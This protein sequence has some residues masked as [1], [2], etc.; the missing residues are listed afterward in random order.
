MTPS[1]VYLVQVTDSAIA[2]GDSNV[3]E[4][5]VHIVFGCTTGNFVSIHV[6]P[7]AEHRN[8]KHAKGIIRNFEKRQKR[9]ST[10]DQFPS[11][12]LSGCDLERND[13]ILRT[14]AMSASLEICDSGD[15]GGT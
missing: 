13:M 2:G 8:Q 6:S 1:N 11:I 15:W 4:L 14:S 7:A 9:G 3:F 5:H 10:L 12:D